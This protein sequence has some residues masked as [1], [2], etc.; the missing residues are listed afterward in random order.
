MRTGNLQRCEAVGE[1]HQAEGFRLKHK[2]SLNTLWHF[3]FE[4]SLVF[5]TMASLRPF[6]TK[7]IRRKPWQ[8]PLHYCVDVLNRRQCVDS[9]LSGALSLMQRLDKPLE[10]EM[11][12]GRA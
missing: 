10:I 7:R 3:L 6:Q 9:G 2:K 5:T 11:D 1:I 12:Q 4:P 8:V